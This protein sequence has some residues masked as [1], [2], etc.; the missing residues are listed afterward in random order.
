MNRT[1]F[2]TQL[3]RLLQNISPA[4]REAALRYYNDYFDDAGAENEQEV[5]EALGN[6]ARV[7][8]NIRRDI[9]G[10]PCESGGRPQASDRA[11][12]EYGKTGSEEQSGKQETAWE[13][14]SEN[15][16]TARE[17]LPESRGAESV[18][19]GGSRA[20]AV[21]G[22]YGNG[23]TAEDVSHG[24]GRTA[25]QSGNFREK[26]MPGW[27]VVLITIGLI[28]GSPIILGALCVIFGVL[29]TWLALIFS[30]GVVAV[31]LL[32]VLVVLVA[33][34]AECLFVDPL[35]GIALIG[36]GMICG[37][38]GILFLM[39]TVALAGIATPAVFRGIGRL[40][41]HKRAAAMPDG[42]RAGS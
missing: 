20:S 6:P 4:E 29:V 9:P 2:M 18:P 13:D 31:S 30:V 22:G 5:I 8:E 3:E 15:G 23:Q 1:D 11:V 42:R 27:A 36:G 38:I 41:Y 26:G 17:E 33:V 10:N 35:V 32:I 12:I 14:S 39:L 16:G 7:A 28:L 25:G 40:F 34:G 19:D 37:G 21:N 24:E